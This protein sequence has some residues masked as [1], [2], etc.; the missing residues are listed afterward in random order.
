MKDDS[1][2]YAE[3]SGA[4]RQLAGM[5]AGE[6]VDHLSETHNNLSNSAPNLAPH[7]YST[8]TN[9]V[10]FLNS[11]LP[12]GG[13][14]L[15]QDSKVLPSQAVKSAWLDLHNVVSDPVSVLEHVN[16]GTFNSHH[17]EALTTVYPDLHKEMSARI[18]EEVGK[19]EVIPYQKRI[20]VSKFLGLPLD[21]TLTP[22]SMQA[23]IS[24]AA[25]KQV[26]QAAQGA[27]KKAS[28]VTL[29]Q[30][31]KTSKIYPTNVQ[32]RQLSEKG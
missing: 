21:S 6:L 7:I 1:N 12:P 26:P 28:G 20:S 18:L 14:Y 8:A 9:A 4:I 5:P 24:S 32:E 19:G 16:Q 29:N 22:Q 25:P 10:Q 17:L 11:K 2:E 13:N 30:I 3:K 15:P 27:P 23:I 31:N